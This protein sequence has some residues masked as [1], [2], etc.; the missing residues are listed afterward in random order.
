MI[1]Y[2]PISAFLYVSNLQKYYQEAKQSYQYEDKYFEFILLI[3]YK[4]QRL[5][6]GKRLYFG[7][8]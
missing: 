4:I 7:I 8:K 5:R 1:R 2:D 3:R 6:L